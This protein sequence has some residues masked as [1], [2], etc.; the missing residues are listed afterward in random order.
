MV[1]IT[2]GVMFVRML[3]LFLC[4]KKRGKVEVNF[5]LGDYNGDFLSK[6]NA[7]PL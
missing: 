6:Q 5:K 7:N 1:L 3:H 2:L 4:A